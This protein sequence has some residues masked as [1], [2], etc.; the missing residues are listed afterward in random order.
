MDFVK[1]TI[2]E[3]NDRQCDV[4][5]DKYKHSVGIAMQNISH[6]Q[7]F[8]GLTRKNSRSIWSKMIPNYIADYKTKRNSVLKE[9]DTAAGT[10]TQHNGEVDPLVT[11]NIIS[12]LK[13]D[14]AN[15]QKSGAVT[16]LAIVLARAKKSS[17]PVHLFS[18]CIAMNYFPPKDGSPEQELNTCIRFNKCLSVLSTYYRKLELEE[19]NKKTAFRQSRNNGNKGLW[20]SLKNRPISDRVVNPTAMEVS[21]APIE[22][23]QPFFDHLSS[24]KLIEQNFFDKDCK[25]ICMKFI[26]GSLYE[27]G[28]LDLCKQV[29]GSDHIQQLMDC[30]AQNDKIQHFL[31][32]NNII[33]TTGAI[34]IA[35][36]IKSKH[37]IKTY[38]LA[39]N[40]LD[41]VG[42][43]YICDALADDTVCTDLW[44]KRNPIG[45]QGAIH[46]KNLLEHNNTIE[47]LD[48]HNCGLLDDGCKEIFE[49]LKTNTSLKML[50]LDANG[51]TNA[52]SQCIAE[53][54]DYLAEKDIYGIDSLFLNINRL[55]DDGIIKIVKSM[56]NYNYL[57][58][59]DLGANGCS[60][61]AMEYIYDAFKSHPNLT[62]LS[63]GP[64]K[65]TVDMQEI[66]NCVSDLGSEYIAKLIEENK[67][68]EYFDITHNGITEIGISKI[69]EAFQSN[70]SIIQLPI[71]QYGLVLPQKLVIKLKSKLVENRKIKNIINIEK[72]V[73]FLKHSET[74]VNIDSIYRNNSKL[75]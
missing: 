12:Q 21:V 52:S 9:S 32:G 63:L 60:E 71:S 13:S 70:D 75:I 65:S 58:R 7:K 64:Y 74:I 38:Y 25:S 68:L 20:C 27:D 47:T 59:L 39:G 6:K 28:R 17:N 43:K 49:G 31:L 26:R 5:N 34:A 30:L 72:Y 29:V 4:S 57:K 37:N 46:V 66:T 67:V 73:R 14:F 55:E 16:D 35:N 48:L 8:I 61:K 36:Y 23:L 11:A 10:N 54:F 56:S 24:N 45:S 40:D 18:H 53:Y 42:I 41:K 62:V 1:S 15:M 19:F 33:N 22:E 3:L 51:I 44:L 69:V 50:Y 2:N